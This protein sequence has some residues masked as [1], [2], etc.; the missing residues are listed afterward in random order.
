MEA[1]AGLKARTGSGFRAFWAF[2]REIT[3]DDAYERYIAS[4][5]RLEGAD[6]VPLTR[7]GFEGQ[8]QRLRWSR[9]SRCC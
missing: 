3:G 5:V 9:P 1:R 6:F 2:L 7:R 8:R 4:G